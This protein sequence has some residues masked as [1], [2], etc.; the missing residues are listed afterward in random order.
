MGGAEVGDFAFDPEVGVLGLDLAADFGDEGPD[1]PNVRGGWLGRDRRFWVCGF[2]GIG[3]EIEGGL[4]GGAP[5]PQAKSQAGQGGRG[6]GVLSH[7]GSVYQR[8]CRG[9]MWA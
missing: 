8:M 6:I 3:K 5:S 1:G 2:W 4:G 9:R 7:E